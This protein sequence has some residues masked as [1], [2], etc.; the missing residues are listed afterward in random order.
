MGTG[1]VAMP[2][3]EDVVVP[4]KRNIHGKIY[5]FVR[6]SKVRDLGKLLKAVNAVWFGNFR[7]NA[8]VAQF[9]RLATA[10]G[11]G[12]EKGEGVRGGLGRENDKKNGEG[13]GGVTR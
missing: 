8:R 4:S 6:F 9:D 7:V 12:D 3:L 5:G 10:V 13:E 2:I 1:F 11:Q